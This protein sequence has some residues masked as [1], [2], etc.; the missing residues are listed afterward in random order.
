VIRE[1]RER[2]AA[3]EWERVFGGI[4]N[5]SA[6]FKAARQDQQ[7]LDG[8]G[9]LARFKAARQDQQRLGG[10]WCLA[11]SSDQ[12]LVGLNVRRVEELKFDSL[13]ECLQS[14]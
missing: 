3:G 5:S 2:A 4:G 7:H 8:I 10:I 9:C 12:Q 6:G 14:V 11:G 1:L 13:C